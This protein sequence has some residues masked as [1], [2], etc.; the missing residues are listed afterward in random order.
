M[1]SVVNQEF[2]YLMMA[3]P[4]N[5]YVIGVSEVYLI[6]LCR[7]DDIISIEEVLDLYFCEHPQ[8]E[9]LFFLF[10]K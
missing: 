4:E 5:K 1:D 8:S 2:N 6:C 7:F 9:V 10:S 3:L